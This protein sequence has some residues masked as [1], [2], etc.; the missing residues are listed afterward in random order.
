MFFSPLMLSLKK[1][2]N[3]TK[4]SFDFPF[5]CG[6]GLFHDGEN[7][8]L[9]AIG[10]KEPAV[11]LL[12]GARVPEEEGVLGLAIFEVSM[13]CCCCCGIQV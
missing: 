8:D 12:L 11:G 10:V 3:P 9:F 6:V 7:N 2:T 5:C 4:F 1:T 13:F